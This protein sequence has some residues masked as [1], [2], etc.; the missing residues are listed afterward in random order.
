MKFY[1]KA[2]ILAFIIFGLSFSRAT[3]QSATYNLDSFKAD[4]DFLGTV[5]Q[6]KLL[7]NPF[8]T[9]PDP[10]FAKH[11]LSD[12][13]I[14]FLCD[15]D[16]Q[17]KNT[18][19]N[20][21]TIYKGGNY[22]RA[23]SLKMNWS[24]E[25]AQTNSAQ[26]IADII[27]FEGVEN[28]IVRIGVGGD[29]L[30]FDDPST[31]VSFLSDIAG[32][33]SGRTFYAIAGPNEP[34]IER[35]AAPSC[36]PP[37]QSDPP[38]T[39]SQF[40]D[41]VGPKLAT[42]M[43]YIIAHK[44]SNVR[45][46]SPAFNLTSF[47]FYDNTGRADGIPLAMA[48]SGAN[49]AGLDAVAGNIYPAGDS[50]QNIWNNHVQSV[51]TQLGKP[52][53]ITETGP[54][55]PLGDLFAGYDSSIYH[56]YNTSDQDYYLQPIKGLGTNEETDD[57]NQEIIRTDLINQGYQAFCAAP[58][59]EAVATLGP[60]E[61]VD[62]FVNKMGESTELDFESTQVVDFTSAKVPLWRDIKGKQFLFT[63]IEEFWGFKDT[64]VGEN[65]TSEIN[66]SPINSLLSN[67]QRC[68]A[69]VDILINQ[70]VMCNKLKNPDVCV[71]YK[72]P[73]PDTSF[74]VKS[75]LNAYKDIA[76]A[77]YRNKNTIEKTCEK[78][79]SS[80]L[81]TIVRQGLLFTPL[82]IDRVYR[83][84]FLVISVEQ[85]PEQQGK[86]YNF[87]RDDKSNNH[88]VLA[89][90]FKVPDIGT[91][92][93]ADQ[94]NSDS[95]AHTAWNDPLSLSNDVLNTGEQKENILKKNNDFFSKINQL[96]ESSSK[97]PQDAT[98]LI[99][100]NPATAPDSCGD[101]LGA[102]LISIIN[103][104]D[105]D[106]MT[107]SKMLCNKYSVEPASEIYDV[108]SLSAQGD[109]TNFKA[110][111][112]FG[113]QIIDALLPGK[114]SEVLKSRWEVNAQTWKNQGDSLID[115]NF[116]LVYPAGMELESV[117]QSLAATF[118]AKDELTDLNH[119]QLKKQGFSVQDTTQ[120]LIGGSQSHTFPN[121]TKCKWV[122]RESATPGV[123]IPVWECEDA[124]FTGAIEAVTQL[125]A[126]IIGGGLGY[127]MRIIQLT[128]HGLASVPRNYL[129]TCKT[130][131][132]F[133]LGK[134]SGE[135]VAPRYSKDD[136]VFAE[137]GPY[138]GVKTDWITNQSGNYIICQENKC[139]SDVAEIGEAG[140]FVDANSPLKIKA[141]SLFADGASLVTTNSM[142]PMN[143]AQ[144]K[145]NRCGL[146]GGAKTELWYLPKDETDTTKINEFSYWNSHA[147]RLI[148]TANSDSLVNLDI[149]INVKPGYYHFNLNTAGCF[150]G[151][152]LVLDQNGQELQDDN[153]NRVNF[154][155][156][157][158]NAFEG[159]KQYCGQIAI[160]SNMPGQDGST[161]TIYGCS[162]NSSYDMSL[163]GAC[164][165]LH[166]NN[167]DQEN[168]DAWSNTSFSEAG[169]SHYKS[170]FR[171]Q[172]VKPDQGDAYKCDDLFPNVIA[173]VNCAQLNDV[174]TFN[175]PSIS[176]N[177]GLD[178]NCITDQN[179]PCTKQN[180]QSKL[181][182]YWQSRGK[183][184]DQNELSKK[185][186][187]A[188][189]ICQRESGG[190]ADA[191]NT[192]CI[193]GKTLDYSV[194]LF[195]INLLAHDCNQTFIDYGIGPPP[196]CVLD[197][198]T[199]ATNKR[200]DCVERLTNPDNNIQKMLEMS[201]GG[202]NWHPWSA[203]RV[204]GLIE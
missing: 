177:C 77:E 180:L 163:N 190:K 49:F 73:I 74:T 2:L 28:V 197:E 94:S 12:E 93:R 48:R 40:Y 202:N 168:S 64:V 141:K 114:D 62:L 53:V 139:G 152:T 161:D 99:R 103:G 27:N 63:S 54:W 70:E 109:K 30:G 148:Y 179:N 95:S 100:C 61:I 173:E 123:Q 25:I 46:L 158:N 196:Y 136:S 55:N 119:Y 66:S 35:W 4:L 127:W 72:R 157:E 37:N 89:V 65:T 82:N 102:A 80:D 3:A 160:N 143:P 7:F 32:R 174:A 76:G 68:Q 39:R 204:C 129:A 97:N 98:N 24:L 142:V 159:K 6:G 116:Y 10:N 166:G 23:R 171:R 60:G 151:K 50:M 21:G 126:R 172:F 104:Q 11:R 191:V 101:K 52:V 56:D 58:K 108:A 69:S 155:I 137:E 34:D 144:E 71:L 15:S 193:T 38:A 132:Q 195:Q 165:G 189:I 91:N 181:A 84:A 183:Q 18:G 36:S 5:S 121:P 124:T 147:Y 19:V 164:G 135:D 122:M 90:A 26:A 75:L 156:I 134:C 128:L 105:K 154:F 1:L 44:P 198:S 51:I 13:Q 88:A 145:S 8:G 79:V 192:G 31:Y 178:T 85:I 47:M 59:Y 83:P 29:S 20:F 67:Q 169:L 112:N 167:K 96:S 118:F 186:T 146:N 200:Q 170:I 81:N 133:L 162:L 176:Q 110:N 194:G 115:I 130:T 138:C 175:C 43:N 201:S 92:K 187:E 185:A 42:Y 120:E 153:P 9:N 131:E 203:A 78:L 86:L 117:E 199:E 106:P 14:R 125:P 184:L 182:A 188:S 41:C 33:V 113:N 57:K 22:Q 45:L 150:M 140:Y 111:L 107:K 16:C 87:F 17:T 149:S